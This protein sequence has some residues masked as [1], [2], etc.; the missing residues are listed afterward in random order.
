[1]NG[2]SQRGRTRFPSRLC[3]VNTEPDM[4]LKLTNREIMT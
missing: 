2:E 1:M 4:G 3:T